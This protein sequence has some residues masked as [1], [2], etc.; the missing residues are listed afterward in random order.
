MKL[1][2]TVLARERHWKGLA[3][4]SVLDPNQS[5]AIVKDFP[6]DFPTSR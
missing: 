3:F 4:S 6:N 2:L 5:E 1:T